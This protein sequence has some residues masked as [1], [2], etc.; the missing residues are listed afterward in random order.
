MRNLNCLF[1]TLKIVANKYP[2]DMV[3]EQLRDI[4]RIA[5]NIDIALQSVK[6]KFTSELEICDLGGGIGL[7][8]VGCA[9]H[10]LKRTV[11]IDDF[12]DLVNHRVGDSILDLHRSHGVEVV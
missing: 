9:A 5:F 3:D 6:P 1:D 11:L 8:S 4:S 7:F 10:G 2:K 12:N